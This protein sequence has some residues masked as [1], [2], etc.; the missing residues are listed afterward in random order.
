M[1]RRVATYETLGVNAVRAAPFSPEEQAV[2]WRG[3]VGG[4]WN[5]GQINVLNTDRQTYHVV[6][7]L[8]WT[9]G[10]HM[11]KFGGD[12]RWSKSD[13]LTNNRVDPQFQF[14]GNRTNNALGD[15][16]LGLPSRFVMGSLRINRIRNM[17][18]N[19]YIQDDWKVLPNLT[20]GMGLRW[21]PYHQFYSADDELSV[22]LPGQQSSSYPQ[23]P[24]GLIYASD[25]GI[26]RGGAPRDLNNFA[27]RI[28]IAWQPSA[29]AKTAI[30]AGY[31]SPTTCRCSI[32]SASS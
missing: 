23:A 10:G 30:R 14:N 26:P 8:L 17:G 32:R 20:L 16:F 1:Q 24:P 28:G 19:L 31:G 22:F 29:N 25:A 12:Y 4:Y 21:E 9:R 18:S 15:F 7:D 13:R 5:L 3:N 2:T 27:P 11:I 6:Y